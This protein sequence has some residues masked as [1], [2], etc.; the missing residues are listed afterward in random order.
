M[1]K[2]IRGY[3]LTGL[4]F[5]LPI[6]VTVLVISSLIDWLHNVELMIPQAYRPSDIL[7]Y[8][9]PG[10]ILVFALMFLVLTGL[11]VTNWLGQKFIGIWES[12][13]ERIP[14]V[15]LI[16][17]T[18]KQMIQAFLMSNGKSFRQ[19]V[20][21]EYPRK[22]LWT[23]AFLTGELSVD[24]T[25]DGSSQTLYSVFVPTTPNPTSGFFLLVKAG[26]FQ[27]VNI[28][29]EHALKLILSLGALKQPLQLD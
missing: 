16:Y 22:D 1:I 11:L 8:P 21:I 14:L 19:V 18:T 23:L 28:S 9:V 4:V 26:E 15:R 10:L 25:S 20:L 3:L 13:L 7:G 12:F 29:A 6:F 17:Q 27:K 24:K 2:K 5:W